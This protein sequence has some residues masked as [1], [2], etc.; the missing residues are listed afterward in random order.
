M[1]DARIN[2]SKPLEDKELVEV[3]SDAIKTAIVVI[4]PSDLLILH[5]STREFLVALDKAAKAA[6]GL[7]HNQANTTWLLVR[8]TIERIRQT[9]MAI[10]TRKVISM[11]SRNQI[12]Q[13]LQGV[14]LKSAQIASSKAMSRQSVL[15][16]LS[17]REEVDARRRNIKLVRE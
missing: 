7:A 5:F 12:A 14:L 15:E 1:S 11:G 8:D 4:K 3:F 6:N 13:V 10:A 2:S 9:F 17:K 16:N